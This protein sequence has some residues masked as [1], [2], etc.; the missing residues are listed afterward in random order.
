MKAFRISRRVHRPT[1]LACLLALSFLIACGQSYGRPPVHAPVIEDV[2]SHEALVRARSD[3]SGNMYVELTRVL[4]A[5]DG[6]SDAAWSETRRVRVTAAKD[7]TGELLFVDLEP[8]TEYRYRVWFEPRPFYAAWFFGESSQFGSS[9]NA[10]ADAAAGSFRTAQGTDA[11]Q[12]AR[13]IFGGDIAGRLP[14]QRIASR[15]AIEFTER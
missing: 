14:G 3:A 11:P 13:F 4:E 8:A 1:G 7:Y 9:E 15:Y 10:P 5:E 12:A 6:A 2:G